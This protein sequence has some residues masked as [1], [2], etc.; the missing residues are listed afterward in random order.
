M[1][2]L[3]A[4][5]LVAPALGQM[6]E[7]RL[8]LCCRKGGAHHCMGGMPSDT[9]MVHQRCPV[10]PSTSMAA[11]AGGWIVGSGAVDTDGAQVAPMTVR[12]VEA[13]YRISYYRSRQKRGPPALVLS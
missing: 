13:G 8:L 1:L 11:H 5:P 7:T 9:P 2:L 12:Q 6:A 4:L 10:L 3:L